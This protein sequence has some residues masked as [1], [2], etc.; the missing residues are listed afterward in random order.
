MGHQKESITDPCGIPVMSWGY[1][2]IGGLIVTL[3]AG[4]KMRG[5]VK[6]TFWELL[7]GVP[8]GSVLGPL[9]FII[10]MGPLEKILRSLVINFHFYADDIQI[11]VT[12]NICCWDYQT[13]SYTNFKYYYIQHAAACLIM[14]LPKHCH[15]TDTSQ[16]H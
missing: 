13:T 7:F 16:I 6:S 15:I 5:G 14:K 3:K 10:Y 4:R 9:L 12:F 11:Y 8:Q 1:S 2:L